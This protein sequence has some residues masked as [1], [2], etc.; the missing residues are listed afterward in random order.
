MFGFHV[1]ARDGRARAGRFST[2]HGEVAT[3]AFM[4]V[5]TRAAVKGVRPDELARLG[6]QIVL[7][8]TYHLVLRPG[9]ER[10]RELGGLH[11][12]MGWDGPVLTDSGGYQ[13]FSLRE[14][15]SIDED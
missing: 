8:N 2:P 4:P 14:L 5:G 10:V 9:A 11:R 15:T 6:T 7:A 12:F 1:E 13:V 3:P